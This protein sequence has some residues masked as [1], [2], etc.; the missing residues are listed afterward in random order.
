MSMTTTTEGR[1]GLKGRA[2]VSAGFAGLAYLAFLAVFLY[3]VAFVADTAVP[4]T[5]DSGGPDAG[6]PTAVAIDVLLL[7]LFA[8]Q[9]SVMARPAFKRR[10]TRLV[11][12][13]VER[14]CYVLAASAVFALTFWQWRPIPAE[15]WHVHAAAARAVLWALFGLGWVLVVAM[16]FAIDHFDMVGLRQVSRYLRGR[17]Q[18]APAFQLPLPY[19][20]VRHP[21]MTGFFLAFIATP[22]M[23]AGHLLFALSSCGYIVVA[24]R[25]EE[26]DLAAALPEYRDYAAR[27]PRFLP[28]P[29]RRR[30]AASATRSL[31]NPGDS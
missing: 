21:M 28:R 16:T 29:S 30:A 7:T 25:L 14:S 22:V 1:A 17:R 26:R 12:H 10:W 6:T 18:A 9:H 4:R 20:L 23:T 2:A 5:I 27:T 13:H 19:R 31:P 3:A 11:P 15:V 24:V 8:V